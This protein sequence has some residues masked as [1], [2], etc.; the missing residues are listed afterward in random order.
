MLRAVPAI[1]LDSCTY[2]SCYHR[3]CSVAIKEKQKRTRILILGNGATLSF[4]FVSCSGQRRGTVEIYFLEDLKCAFIDYSNFEI[5]VGESS[6]TI[7]KLPSPHLSAV[8]I[9]ASYELK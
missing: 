1:S 2:S 5:M 8:L 3:G 7:G 4:E 9:A 6:K